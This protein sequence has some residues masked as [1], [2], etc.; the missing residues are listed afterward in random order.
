MDFSSLSTEDVV[1]QESSI[2]INNVS[3]LP[4]YIYLSVCLSVCLYLFFL[5]INKHLQVEN[6][7]DTQSLLQWA[8]EIISCGYT[9][10]I[11]QDKKE[12]I[13]R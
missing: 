10:K 6:A 12:S 1:D 9:S 8:D 7:T 11:T 2:L 3:G 5:P 4:L 13:I